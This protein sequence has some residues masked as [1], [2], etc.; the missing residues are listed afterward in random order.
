ML[1]LKENLTLWIN[2][3]AFLDPMFR[4]KKIFQPK[5]S[6]N[7]DPRKK[8][9]EDHEESQINGSFRMILNNSIDMKAINNS[10]R[11]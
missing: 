3:N 6:D 11:H 1:N 7:S 4:P 9:P 5:Y 2:P 10:L 8:P